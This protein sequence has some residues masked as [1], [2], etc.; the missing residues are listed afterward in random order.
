[1]SPQTPPSRH[2]RD[3]SPICPAGQSRV[4]VPPMSV[5][6]HTTPISS[7]SWQA[8]DAMANA[9]AELSTASVDYSTTPLARCKTL[10]G[11]GSRLSVAA[12]N[13]GNSRQI[14]LR[15]LVV[16]I[17]LWRALITSYSSAICF[18]PTALSNHL[19]PH[20]VDAAL[21]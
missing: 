16:L 12:G 8:E 3:I 7:F 6:G 1:M 18:A 15:P 9:Y 4:T 10:A 14:R 13:S 5:V 11:I 19:S 17:R 2:A 20:T 21:A